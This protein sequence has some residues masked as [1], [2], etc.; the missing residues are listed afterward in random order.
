MDAVIDVSEVLNVYLNESKKNLLF[1]E[2][3]FFPSSAKLIFDKGNGIFQ[4]TFLNFNLF[5]FIVVNFLETSFIWT[6]RTS[7]TS[8]ID[9]RDFP[10]PL[11]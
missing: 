5:Y 1:L 2:R 6:F 7:G 9:T 10:L 8:V 11:S 4:N 3:F